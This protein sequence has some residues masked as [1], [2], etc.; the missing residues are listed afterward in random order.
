MHLTSLLKL[1]NQ[2]IMRW[3]AEEELTARAEWQ[4][5]KNA[6]GVGVPID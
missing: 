5:F 3:M 6:T 2:S 4:T 1:M